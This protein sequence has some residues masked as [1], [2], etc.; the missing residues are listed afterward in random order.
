[1]GKTKGLDP[2]TK[3]VLEPGE[4]AI[5]PDCGRGKETMFAGCRYCNWAPL[6]DR[7]SLLMAYRASLLYQRDRG[8]GEQESFVELRK[9]GDR[10]ADGIPPDLPV[11]ELLAGLKNIGKDKEYRRLTKETEKR[12]LTAILFAIGMLL[13]VTARETLPLWIM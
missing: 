2:R 13:Y 6:T 1:M 7:L 8:H 3:H 5:C 10:I 11:P 9:L 12:D 4:E